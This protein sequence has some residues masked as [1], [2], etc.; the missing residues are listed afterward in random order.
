MQAFEDCEALLDSF[1]G[2]SH[3][4][5]GIGNTYMWKNLDGDGFG[6][7]IGPCIPYICVGGGY[8]AAGGAQTEPKDSSLCVQTHD[9]EDPGRLRTNTLVKIF[10]CSLCTF[11]PCACTHLA[12]PPVDR[13]IEFLLTRIA[14]VQADGGACSDPGD[15]HA[16][17][18]L[19]D[20]Q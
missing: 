12:G 17:T 18:G 15:R 9:R 11:V 16:M 20:D 2:D 3:V 14:W 10:I 5:I 7:F 4:H 6:P 19:L 13:T 8:V 1:D